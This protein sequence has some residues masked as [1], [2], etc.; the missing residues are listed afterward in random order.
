MNLLTI[1]VVGDVVVG[2]RVHER[3]PDRGSH[4]AQRQHDG[5][6]LTH[7]RHIVYKGKSQC[8]GLIRRV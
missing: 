3:R 6:C 8:A 5:D 7:D 1:V 2:M 4:Q